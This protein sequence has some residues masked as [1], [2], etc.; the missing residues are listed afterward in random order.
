MHA[1]KKY[2]FLIISFILIIGT[3]PTLQAQKGDQAIRVGLKL[4]F[5]YDIGYYH[6]FSNRIG[7]HA[8]AQIVTIPFS[9]VSI[10]MMNLFGAD[11]NIT[12]ILE[13]PFSIG[14]GIDHGWHYYF[15]T[16]NRR[17]YGGISA[18]WMS[19]LKRDIE[20]KTIDKAFAGEDNGCPTLDKCPV[21]PVQQI[22]G[23][24]PLT[25]NTNYVNIGL[26]FGVIFQLANKN[27]ELRLEGELSKTIISRHHLQSDYRFITPI[28]ER[29]NEALKESMN[30]YGWFPSLNIYY[31][32]K[33]NM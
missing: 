32:Y 6:R 33:L 13:E 11:P 26:T 18:Q 27:A 12:A 16:D 2:I 24:K 23:S 31:I 17:Y 4:P 10:G 9:G 22:A 20:D 7:M 15:G 29:T 19:L 28:A 30:K 14:A 3:I 8:S 1:I 5:T 25:L 21:N